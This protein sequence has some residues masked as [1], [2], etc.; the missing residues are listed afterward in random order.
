[1]EPQNQHTTTAAAA[2]DVAA[3]GPSTSSSPD[4]AESSEQPEVEAAA[5]P[6]NNFNNSHPRSRRR[7]QPT[8]VSTRFNVPELSSGDMRDDVWSCL[9]VLV[10]FWF[11][12]ASMTLILGF[13][14]SEELQLGPSCSRLVVTNQLFVQSIKGQLEEQVSGPML[15]GFREIPPLDVVTTWM[16]SHSVSV[17]ANYHQASESPVFSLILMIFMLLGIDMEMTECQEECAMLQEW[18]YYLNTGSYVD[19]SYDVKSPSYAPMS[20]V[21]AQGEEN[22]IEWVDE[23]SY[24]NSTLSWNIIYGSGKIEQEIMSSGTYYIAIGNLNSEVVEVVLNFTIKAALYNT[25]QAIFKCT[26][27]DSACIFDLSLLQENVVVLTSPGPEQ[28]NHENRARDDTTE[29]GQGSQEPLL[30]PKDDDLSSWGSS[31]DSASHDDDDL[32]EQ[33]QDGKPQKEGDQS[34]INPRRLCV[35][36]YDAP[37]DCFFLPCGHC[38]ACF[39]CGSKIAE[40]VGTCPICRRKMKK[41]KVSID[42]VYDCPTPSQEQRI[43]YGTSPRGD[44]VLTQ[45][46]QGSHLQLGPHL[47]P[48]SSA[49][50]SLK[51]S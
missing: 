4:E 26:L 36:C 35:I 33:I 15:Y 38:A 34:N 29:G 40:E 16:E 7:H 28:A 49:I 50:A 43:K 44:S 19:I 22:L 1:M 10:T 5:Q 42:C 47:Q 31:Y 46:V 9:V 3:A 32:E 2:S 24:P 12:A 51:L 21:I 20:L 17:L 41:E 25:T 18:E 6:D 13:Y 48:P 45:H 11:F 8:S 37:R 27:T 39:A 14:G 30:S 23:P